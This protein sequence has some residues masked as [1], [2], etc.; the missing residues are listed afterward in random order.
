MIFSSVMRIDFSSIISKTT[1]P[2][3]NTNEIQQTNSQS[4]KSDQP[5]TKDENYQILAHAPKLLKKKKKTRF[6]N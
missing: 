1:I 3:K 2:R 4:T 6:I 5:R